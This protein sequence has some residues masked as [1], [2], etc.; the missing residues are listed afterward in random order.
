M[1]AN[2]GK[3]QAL[4][5]ELEKSDLA[6]AN[7]FGNKQKQ[8]PWPVAGQVTAK[9]GETKAVGK[10]RWNGMFFAAPEGR[11]IRAVA[12][13]EV[14]YADWLNGFGLLLIIDH[15]HGYMSLYGGNRELLADNGETLSKGQI[16]ATVGNSGSQTISGS[17]LRNSGKFGPCRP[18]TVD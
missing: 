8:L 15:G 2:I 11:K 16:I 14:V 5:E 6:I 13:G 18:I 17:L 7:T 9:F 10:L 3:L 4:V 1:E 12:D